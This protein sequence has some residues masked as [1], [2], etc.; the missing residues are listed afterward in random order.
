M[1]EDEFFYVRFGEDDEAVLVGFSV[2]IAEDDDV[3]DFGVEVGVD[4]VVV[5]DVEL[6]APVFEEGGFDLDEVEVAGFGGGDVYAFVYVHEA[7]VVASEDEFAE[8][9]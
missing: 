6:D 9:G 3:E 2:E 7:G 1:V 8:D 5:A 4:E